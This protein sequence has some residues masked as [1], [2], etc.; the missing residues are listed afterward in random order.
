MA[1]RAV[2]VWRRDWSFGVGPGDR[3][4]RYGPFGKRSVPVWGQGRS[5]RA[6]HVWRRDWS[7]GVGMGNRG[8]RYGPFGKRS[9]PVRGQGWLSEPSMSGGA[10]GLSGLGWGIGALDMD[11][12]EKGPCLCGGRDG[13]PSRPCLAAGLGLWGWIGESGR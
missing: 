8:V 12:L 2:H 7:F 6:V 4:V 1:L 13:S 10:I 9:V 5:L 11:L 3:A